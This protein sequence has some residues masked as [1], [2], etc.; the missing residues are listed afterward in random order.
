MS[1]ARRLCAPMLTLVLTAPATAADLWVAARVHGSVLALADGQW[2]ELDEGDG[3]PNGM[4]V[5]TLQ[6]GRV[7]LVRRDEALALDTD[8]A[9]RTTIVGDWVTVEQF[10]GVL[11]LSDPGST[12]YRLVTPGLTATARGASLVSRV[13]AAGSTV[14]VRAGRVPVSTGDHQQLLEAGQSVSVSAGANEPPGQSAARAG[15]APDGK[16]AAGSNTN[17]GGPEGNS[18]AGPGRSGDGTGNGGQPANGGQNGN[19]GGNNEG[20]SG[21]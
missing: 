5:R 21:D 3:V 9:V 20:K 1:L 14:S 7:V 6:A 11:S 17:P 16:A 15:A 18:D 2:S 19:T 4:A 10:A 12:R 13:G 8:T